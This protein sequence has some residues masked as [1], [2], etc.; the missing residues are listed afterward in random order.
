[1]HQHCIKDVETILENRHSA[2]FPLGELVWKIPSHTVASGCSQDKR[3]VGY[4]FH[5]L[6]QWKSRGRLNLHHTPHITLCSC[7]RGSRGPPGDVCPPLPRPASTLVMMHLSRR[8]LWYP[9]EHHTSPGT[10]FPLS[11]SF[12]FPHGPIS[13]I[14][15]FNFSRLSLCDNLPGCVTYD[16]IIHMPNPFSLKA[17]FCS[18][19]NSGQQK[20]KFLLISYPSWS[21]TFGTIHHHWDNKYGVSRRSR[22]TLL[23]G[24]SFLHD[25]RFS[26]HYVGRGVEGFCV[27][28]LIPLRGY[29]QLHPISSATQRT[30]R[31]SLSYHIF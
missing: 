2:H 24:L 21:S 29:C 15:P 18:E 31:I 5:T 10:R 22:Q 16:I 28:Y 4:W 3:A 20:N 13:H 8:E 7:S 30:P 26:R 17:T 6:L 14:S 19:K 25:P 12:L 1:M 23:N 9:D 11:L 27:S